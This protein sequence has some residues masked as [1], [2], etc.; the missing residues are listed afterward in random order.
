MRRRRT[1]C[2]R[3]AGRAK[4]PAAWLT[5]R[6]HYIPF[7]KVWLSP[8][9]WSALLW[10]A[11]MA[12]LVVDLFIPP[13][14]MMLGF[15]LLPPL[16]A[17]TFFPPRQVAWI[18]LA[19]IL[20]AV[21]SGLRFQVLFSGPYILHLAASAAIGTSA[22]VLAAARERQT[23]A[24]DRERRRLRG[25]LDSLLD[26][27]IVLTAV[28]NDEGKIVDFIFSDAN[29]AACAYNKLPREK[30]VGTRLLELL[31]AHRETGLFR[32]YCQVVESGRFL[33]LD[34]YLYPHDVFEEPR[35][36]DIRAAKMDDSISYTWRDVTDRHGM[37]EILEHRARTDE[38][39]KLLNRRA[40]FE[41][42]EDLRGKTPRT[43]GDIAIL[44]V[45]F[46]KFKDI[47]DAYGH[48]AGDEVLRVT[49][50]RLRSC[51]RHS[52]DLGARVGGDEMLVVLHGVHGMKDAAAIA[53]KL[54]R[55]AAAP[56]RFDGTS[57]EATVSVG[58][59]LARAEESTDALVS[60]AD[61][62]MYE[63]KQRGRNQVIT[64]NGGPR[65]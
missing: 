29:E 21:V 1:A 55:S 20:A 31:P 28:R 23:A 45:D 58:V 3:T 27:H 16:I 18:A 17:A 42:I 50:D 8:K 19:A 38:L 32:L 7:P 15:F 65:V 26:P 41:Q 47:N 22:V 12:I 25:T 37:T 34:D 60:R 39:T 61:A 63:A 40:A 44:F 56:V 4:E 14:Y 10:V 35:F 53:E 54:R 2:Y 5:M 43:G 30:L 57:I 51:L 9:S 48:A 62:A 59:A 64:I 49:A 13:A 36:Y 24:A 33:A 11:L 46:D 6:T 52:D